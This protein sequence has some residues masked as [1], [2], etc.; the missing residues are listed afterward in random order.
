[1]TS[2]SGL[3]ST[4]FESERGKKP[5][6]G[7]SIAVAGHDMPPFR[8]EPVVWTQIAPNRQ[9]NGCGTDKDKTMREVAQA[10]T[11]STEYIQIQVGR[12][13]TQ[14][15]LHSSN[16]FTHRLFPLSVS[17]TDPSNFHLSSRIHRQI[18][19]HSIP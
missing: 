16:K 3:S 4:I 11:I 5:P 13:Q 17:Q 2:H 8:A 19:Q 14:K 10:E 7:Q 9:T 6:Q 1:M 18:A 15:F 12:S